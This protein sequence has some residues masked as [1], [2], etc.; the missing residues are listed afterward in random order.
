MPWRV[1]G[2]VVSWANCSVGVQSCPTRPAAPPCD[3]NRPARGMSESKTRTY[4]GRVGLG[5]AAGRRGGSGRTGRRQNSPPRR[6]ASFIPSKASTKCR[7]NV[8]PEARTSDILCKP[9]EEHNERLRTGLL[10][11]YPQFINRKRNALCSW[12]LTSG[13]TP[14]FLCK[15]F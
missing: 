2:K 3:P 1:R 8:S 13:P 10:A 7:L 12:L 9:T 14:L 4:H 6:Q 5:R 15:P 11:V